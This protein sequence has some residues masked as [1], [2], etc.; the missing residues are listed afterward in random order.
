MTDLEYPPSAPLAVNPPQPKALSRRVNV[1]TK[2]TTALEPA[3]FP[4]APAVTNLR[5]A[6][7]KADTANAL[8]LTELA[9][10]QSAG[11]PAAWFIVRDLAADNKQ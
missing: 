5:P 6:A 11:T 9:L 10:R 8:A 4:S 3:A 7:R 1:K 2:E